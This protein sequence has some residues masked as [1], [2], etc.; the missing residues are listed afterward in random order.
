VRLFPVAIVILLAWG[1]LAVGGSPS[2]AGVPVAVF[3]LAT[4]IIGMLERRLS[5]SNSTQPR[6]PYRGVM[7]AMATLVAAI[8]VQ[9]V[10]LPASMVSRLSPN[11]E[12]ADFEKLLA[13]A[14]RRDPELVLVRPADA[15]RPLSIVPSRTWYGLGFVVALSVFVVGAA[16]G[17]TVVGVVR[18]V[19]ALAVLAVVVAALGIYQGGTKSPTFFGLYT[20]L[21]G[22]LDSAPF[23]NRNHQAAWLVMVMSLVFGTFFGGVIRSAKAA[24]PTWRA[25][26]LWLSSKDASAD[27][28]LLFTSLII[29]IAVLATDS[30]A[31]AGMLV[32][33]V[34]TI[35]ILSSR[36]L[37]STIRVLT[38]TTAAVGMVLAAFTISGAVV[39]ER[40]VR[41]PWLAWSTTDER[42]PVWRDSLNIAREFWMT[43]TGF[44]TYGTSMLHYQTVSD[45]FRYIEAH[46]DY[47]QIAAEGGLLVGIP[48]ALLI[49]A[50]VREIRRRFREGRDDTV[51][52]CQRIGAVTGL[53]V[54]AVQSLVDFPLQMPG[55]AVMFATLLAIAIHHAPA[56]KPAASRS[57]T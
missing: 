14:D 41:T 9:L 54:V 21:L 49:A 5:G 2:W 53:A 36:N 24:L 40:V 42:L 4:G 7:I 10:P 57:L 55:N 52:Y 20:P 8:G 11:R 18:I 38:V 3:A 44:N 30:R 37:S 15:L 32:L 43:G 34:F 48:A 29:A 46:N 13:V 33:A 56:A 17:V 25:R 16:H 45:G 51:T 1:V 12:V 19:P 31:G 27:I 39:A 26:I 23:V 6:V 28:L 47:L 50:F 35:A 22:N